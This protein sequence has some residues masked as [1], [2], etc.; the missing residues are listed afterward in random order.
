LT[1]EVRVHS[2]SLSSRNLNLE[3]FFPLLG[4]ILKFS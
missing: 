4:N 2:S 3:V 1:V